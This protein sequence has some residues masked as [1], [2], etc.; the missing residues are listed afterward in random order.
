M[1]CSL[2]SSTEMPMMASY[3]GVAEAAVGLHHPDDLP[4]QLVNLPAPP[5]HRRRGRP[6]TVVAGSGDHRTP[7]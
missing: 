5:T 4:V 3:F 2:G 1:S 6:V 7:V